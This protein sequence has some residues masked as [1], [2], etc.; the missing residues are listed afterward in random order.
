M[1][2]TKDRKSAIVSEFARSKN[3]T[4]RNKTQCGRQ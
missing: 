1:A 2:L 3:D 4:G